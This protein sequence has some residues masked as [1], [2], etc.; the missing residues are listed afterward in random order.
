MK[1]PTAIS[2]ITGSFFE[3]PM[4]LVGSKTLATRR[5]KECHGLRPKCLVLLGTLTTILLVASLLSSAFAT[6]FGIAGKVYITSNAGG[7]LERYTSLSEVISLSDY[8]DGTM[9][10]NHPWDRGQAAIAKYYGN[11]ATGELKAFSYAASSDTATAF[12]GSYYVEMKDTLSFIIPAGT[13]TSGLSATINGSLSGSFLASGTASCIGDFEASFGS[14]T[15]VQKYDTPQTNTVVDLPFTL[16]TW[17][18]RPNTT[19]TKTA[20]VPIIFDMEIGGDGKFRAS[21]PLGLGN[22]ATNDFFDTLEIL[23]LDTPDGYAWTSASGVFLTELAAPVPEPTSLLLLG[24]GLGLIG[25][26]AWRRRR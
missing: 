8:I 1:R 16:T 17:I 6:P 11:L 20:T 3:R 22:S 21:S 19:L 10:T 12:A 13:Y 26:A 24:T 7:T 5:Q 23:S 14:A 4:R 2:L 18:V 9:V 25:T 15:F